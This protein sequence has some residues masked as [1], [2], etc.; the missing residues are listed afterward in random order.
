MFKLAAPAIALSLAAFSAPA[1]AQTAPSEENGAW[2]WEKLE[3][4]K[5]KTWYVMIAVH[6]AVG[7]AGCDTYR[8][9]VSTVEPIVIQGPPQVRAAHGDELAAWWMMYV[10]D[11]APTPYRWLTT[12]AGHEPPEVYFRETREEAM[13][14]FRE[15]GHLRQSRSCSGSKLVGLRT[16]NFKFTPPPGFVRT[17][18]GNEPAPQGVTVARD[19]SP[20][21][22]TP[23]GAT[24]GAR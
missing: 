9:K 21:P 17:E 12:S 8:Y 15:D 22:G 3:S 18:F 24:P 16:R 20:A 2:S 13:Q 10:R 14:A 19:L 4:D 7:P 23:P 5:P 1:F 6:Q 11:R